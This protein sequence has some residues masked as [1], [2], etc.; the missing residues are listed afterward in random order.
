MESYAIVC[1][2][3][4]KFLQIISKA[5]TNH[6]IPGPSAVIHTMDISSSVVRHEIILIAHHAGTTM[7]NLLEDHFL[8][9]MAVLNQ[10]IITMGHHLEG[11][12]QA[13][14]MVHLL[15]EDPLVILMEDPMVIVTPGSQW[16]GM[17][18]RGLR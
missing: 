12:H 5:G 11:A 4:A 16:V 18:A 13:I 8:A 3:Q 9:V 6:N 10:A 17:P 15:E 7:V 2:D 14:S 1:H